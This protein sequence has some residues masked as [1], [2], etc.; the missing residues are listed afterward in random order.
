[1]V[2]VV[3]PIVE[4]HC[5]RQNLRL[6]N[7]TKFWFHLFHSRY[8][9]NNSKRPEVLWTLTLWYS[10]KCV[11]PQYDIH[12]NNVKNECY[13]KRQTNVKLNN[14]YERNKLFKRL[15]LVISKKGKWSQTKNLHFFLVKSMRN[16]EVGAYIPLP[17][18]FFY[19]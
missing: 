19:L 3:I 2:M 12:H 1:M 5:T 4:E 11:Y 13:I 7:L 15:C 10:L 14:A 8:H 16:T 18:R 17:P 9:M 6:P